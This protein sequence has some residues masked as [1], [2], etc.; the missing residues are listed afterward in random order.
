MWIKG[1]TFVPQ[2][3][4]LPNMVVGADELGMYRMETKLFGT[5]VTFIFLG[6]DMP[7]LELHQ[8]HKL[9]NLEVID[10]HAS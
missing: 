6:F 1:N 10:R 9:I 7:D 3:V 4:D 8:K 5:T 2:P